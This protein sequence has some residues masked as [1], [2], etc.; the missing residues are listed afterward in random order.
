MKNFEGDMGNRNF[1]LL[2]NKN[3]GLYY[4]IGLQ[5][6]E[7]DIG[8][9]LVDL[10]KNVSNLLSYM[11][12]VLVFISALICTKA[13]DIPCYTKVLYSALICTDPSYAILL[14][15]TSVISP[16]PTFSRH[17]TFTFLPTE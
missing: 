9:L 15:C 5:N 10:H 11:H 4:I 14:D 3:V 17:F 7:Q 16:H 1:N 2:Q 13:L 8:R 6:M 12:L